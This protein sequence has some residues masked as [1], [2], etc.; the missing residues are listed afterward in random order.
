MVNKVHVLS[1][2]LAHHYPMACTA[3]FIRRPGDVCVH[4]IKGTDE[5]AGG[6]AQR[7]MSHRA[8]GVQ[9]TVLQP[10]GTWR[11][12]WRN[13]NANCGS[14]LETVSPRGRVLGW[15]CRWRGRADL[16]SC[17]VLQSIAQNPPQIVA[18]LFSVPSWPDVWCSSTVCFPRRIHLSCFSYRTVYGLLNASTSGALLPLLSSLL[19]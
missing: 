9:T 16:T 12:A 18:G 14:A 10:A 19:S 1:K 15:Y 13:A 11:A 5:R 8:V 6:P 17:T 7:I 3:H 2:L 4:K